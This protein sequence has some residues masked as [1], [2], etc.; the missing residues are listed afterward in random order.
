MNLEN[1]IFTISS[2]EEFEVVALEVFQFQYKNVKVYREFCDLLKV[3][4]S[5]INSV[6]GIPFLPIQF[7]KSHNVLSSQLPII[8]TFLS[9]GT[10]GMM[11]IDVTR[12]KAN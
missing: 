12:S 8:Q 10:T 11:T 5:T 3:S 9:S 7:F 2:L 6:Q 4:P 1:K